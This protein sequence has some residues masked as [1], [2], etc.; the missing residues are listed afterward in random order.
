M[1]IARA[2]ASGQL[3]GRQRAAAVSDENQRRS[4]LHTFFDAFETLKLIHALRDRAFPPIELR[5]AL[6]QAPFL[7]LGPSQDF[8]EICDAL[9]SYEGEPCEALQRSFR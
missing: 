7:S 5:A 9:A 4:R 8:E 1:R 3:A 6:T 2:P